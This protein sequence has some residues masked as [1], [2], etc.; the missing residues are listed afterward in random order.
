[1][2]AAN[3]YYPD[4]KGEKRLYYQANTGHDISP[5]GIGAIAG[6][7][8]ALVSGT[9]YPEITWT[10]VEN[11]EITVSWEQEG[12]KALLWQASSLN[13]DFREATWQSSPLEG[14]NTVTVRAPSAKT[15]WMAWYVEVQFPV[16]GGMPMGVT[17]QMHVTPETY[18][19]AAQ[20]A[21]A[22]DL[23]GQCQ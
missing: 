16:S 19:H 7:F 20:K 8:D 15:G 14:K 4:L 3:L 11:E 6:F 18:P 2:D 1:V 9:P 22:A 21:A 13:R 23:V 17:T 5:D 12:G 10:P